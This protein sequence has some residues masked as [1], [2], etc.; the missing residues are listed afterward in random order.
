MK[1]YE[2]A[3]QIKAPKEKVWNVLTDFEQYPQWNSVLTLKNNPN[4]IP[5]QKF[6][7]AITQPNNKKSQFKAILLHKE[8]FD[9]FTARQI[10]LGSW[11]FEA[12]HFFILNKTDDNTLEFVQK[13]ELKGIISTLMS[14]LVL[15]E[16][17]VFKKMNEELKAYV[18]Q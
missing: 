9:S 5:G 16:L 17:E 6:D 1:I 14:K 3:V 8:K 13:W 10:I 7:V 4:L 18:E 15:K 12:T 2:I 11:F